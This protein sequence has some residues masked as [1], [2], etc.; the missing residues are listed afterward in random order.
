ML[1]QPTGADDKEAMATPHHEAE[2]EQL[3]V[4]D[5]QGSD[6]VVGH[7]V[8]VGDVTPPSLI[9]GGANKAEGGGGET[10][11]TPQAMDQP[12]PELSTDPSEATAHSIHAEEEGELDDKSKTVESC[13]HI[14]DGEEGNLSTAG[15]Q[16]GKEEGAKTEIETVTG[17]GVETA[18]DNMKRQEAVSPPA[19]A[20]M[21][22]LVGLIGIDEVSKKNSTTEPIYVLGDGLVTNRH[23][24]A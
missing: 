19:A 20:P 24:K 15:G 14:D 6:G 7:S 5:I 3:A 11:P 1:P 18:D 21:D 9:A 8:H 10:P 17:V 16:E 13:A 22:K 4:V 23:C 2:P 12:T